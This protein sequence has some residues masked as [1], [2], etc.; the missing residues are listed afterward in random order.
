MECKV[1]KQAYDTRNKFHRHLQKCCG[2]SQKQYYET[3]YPRFDLWDNSI[4]EFKDFKQYFATQFN[5]KTNA[6]SF[7]KEKSK[8]ESGK[9]EAAQVIRSYFLE[10]E[11]QKAPTQSELR[12]KKIPSI[13]GMDLIFGDYYRLCSE[14][15]LT[16]R[17]TNR[18]LREI[19]DVEIVT[20]TRE[21]LPVFE[22]F[23]EKLE[24]GDYTTYS[25]FKG[26]F[27]ERKSLEDFIGTFSR[28]TNFERFERE[29]QRAEELGLY[30]VVVCEADFETVASWKN[31]HAGGRSCGFSAL[32]KMCKFMQEFDNCQFL[33]IKKGRDFREIL[34]K[35]L[36]A[37][38]FA[39]TSDLQYLHDTNQF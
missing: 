3:F 10:R 35:I 18:V 22:D 23:V 27:V 1:C 6:L 24:V 37:G 26:V 17:L 12:C 4:V 15:N 11:F 29:L 7:F 34:K 19:K 36:G 5:N 8:T 9:E 25:D 16:P 21:Q 39:K 38:D 14:L 2:K 33:F 20:D 13:I 31:L 30:I 32:T 28:K